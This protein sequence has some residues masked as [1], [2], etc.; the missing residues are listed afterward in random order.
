MIFRR[1]VRHQITAWLD[2]QLAAGDAARVDAHLA[3]CPSC[4]E[5]ARRVQAVSALLRHAPTVEAPREIWTSLASALDDRAGRSRAATRSTQ[6]TGWW[7]AAAAA[8]VALVVAG[9]WWP[10]TRV[11]PWDVVRLDQARQGRLEAGA[12]IETTGET[13]AAIRVGGIGR[14]DLEPG[15]RLQ[16]LAATP[17][18]HR[19]NLARGR[20]SV[21]IVAPPRVFFVNT[22][23]STVVDL[24]C[25]YTM[26]VAADGSGI[27][28]VT[29]G[30]ASLEWDDRES[31]V[32]AGASATTRPGV[33]P[34]TPA[35][36]DAS[37]ALRAALREF[38]YGTDRAGA[39]ETVLREA[40]PRD[41]LTLWH[42]LSRVAEADRVRVFDRLV[43]LTPLPSGV[44][45]ARALALDA[46]TLRHWR[47]ELAWTW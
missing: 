42:L 10:S 46:A 9:W 43:A 14:V 18:E 20:I 8:A 31:L 17:A 35:F 45:R 21:E 24:G 22:P 30:W 36:D 47:E 29:K 12:W 1:H 27:L 7:W 28:R 13:T 38:D 39:L 34:G 41:T 15:T 16:L 3:Q 11:N 33:P 5:A 19:L 2:G 4:R 32:P 6:A 40:T 23:A 37:D 25:A 26:D 44:D